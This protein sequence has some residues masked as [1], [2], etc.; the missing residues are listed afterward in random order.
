MQRVYLLPTSLDVFVG[1]ALPLQVW[2]DEFAS[3]GEGRQRLA[4]TIE[5]LASHDAIA[6]CEPHVYE[7]LKK[8][9]QS[10]QKLFFP[11]AVAQG[12]HAAKTDRR[13]VLHPLCRASPN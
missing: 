6:R 2:I 4:E 8:R 11:D 9:V 12:K 7:M 5:C 13:N 1:C 10:R 3:I